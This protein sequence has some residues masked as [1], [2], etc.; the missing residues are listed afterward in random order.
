MLTSYVGY[1]DSMNQ[2]SYCRP[3]WMTGGT[4]IWMS[5]KHPTKKTTDLDENRL[6]D[7]WF[8]ENQK[9]FQPK[10]QVSEVFF[11][12]RFFC[13]RKNYDIFVGVPKLVVEIQVHP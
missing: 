13:D 10:I 1:L 6:D 2:C 7:W 3:G 12:E 9:F 5:V 11:L 4:G 8:H